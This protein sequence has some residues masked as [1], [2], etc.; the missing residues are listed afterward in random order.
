MLRTSL[1]KPSY[2]VGQTLLSRHRFP[3]CGFKC[4]NV[5][6][7]VR[8]NFGWAGL[9]LRVG[10]SRI[11]CK[12]VL[13][14]R[15]YSVN[16][17]R[18]NGNDLGKYILS[19]SLLAVK[20]SYGVLAIIPTSFSLAAAYHWIVGDPWQVS[21]AYLFFA[22]TG[23]LCLPLSAVLL[24]SLPVVYI[25]D[26]KDRWFLDQVQRT[27]AKLTCLP[28]FTPTVVQSEK[29]AELLK[30]GQPVVFI[31]NHESWADIYSLLWLPYPIRFL[32]KEQIFYIP[33]VGWSMG[34]IGHVGVQRSRKSSRKSVVETCVK[35]VSDGGSV[36]L[37]PEGTRS[38][39]GSLQPFKRGAFVISEEADVPIIPIS[40][41]G[42]GGLMPPYHG[43]TWLESGSEHPV[44]LVVH[45]PLYPGS[46]E[47]LEE[48][49]NAARIVIDDGRLIEDGTSIP[50][51][52][53]PTL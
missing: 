45:D 33:V 22:W 5:S 53:S 1:I 27:W 11:Q 34:V 29:T 30:S 8:R 6:T 21:R 7:L 35:K 28:F 3:V 32:S 36:F 2:G 38:K 40:I 23:Y 9:S 41:R 14:T 18:T 10:S 24:M 46:Y 51:P 37:F 44:T 50:I 12:S 43:Q 31:S 52:L 25:Y 17:L 39:D 4:R 20:V 48:Y 16:T 42:T 13:Y 26:W 19:K 15:S 49:Q 47:S